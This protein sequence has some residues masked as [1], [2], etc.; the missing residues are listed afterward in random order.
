MDEPTGVVYDL[1]REGKD[2]RRVSDKIV[3]MIKKMR[4]STTSS[5]KLSPS[6]Y[7][8]AALS[9]DIASQ[10]LAIGLLAAVT[11]RI[12]L[13]SNSKRN[14]S[15]PEILNWGVPRAS[16]FYKMIKSIQMD[17]LRMPTGHE[18]PT[19]LYRNTNTGGAVW[20][21]SLLYQEKT[22][23]DSTGTP[24]TMEVFMVTGSVYLI[25]EPIEDILRESRPDK[26]DEV[27]SIL[28]SLRGVASEER[29]SSEDEGDSEVDQSST[30]AE[31]KL[32]RKNKAY[33]VHISTVRVKGELTSL[34]GVSLTANEM[35]KLDSAIRQDRIQERKDQ[36]SYSVK[37]HVQESQVTGMCDIM[38]FPSEDNTYQSSKG[39]SR[40]LTSY[41]RMPFLSGGRFELWGVEWYANTGVVTDTD[42]EGIHI[43]DILYD[44]APDGTDAFYKRTLFR[45]YND[46]DKSDYDDM[47]KVRGTEG[48][49]LYS[50]WTFMRQETAEEK[51]AHEKFRVHGPPIEECDPAQP[52]TLRRLIPA[53]RAAP[54]LM[55]GE[56]EE[57]SKRQCT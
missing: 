14:E 15:H 20:V 22:T 37:I 16:P 45:A 39:P 7:M 31:P 25:W 27:K 50:L 43:G 46:K 54:V 35:S 56:D 13:K 30:A 2:V 9:L 41:I 5:R 55:D 11:E 12:M 48:V 42:V 36:Y 8:N 44:P 17:V 23:I 4:F 34:V 29:G 57:E 53:L 32:T 10:E 38:E 52:D 26:A 6:E 1:L 49:G 19:L 24:L 18:N 33:D 51:A 21:H 40:A 3:K 47:G 28:M